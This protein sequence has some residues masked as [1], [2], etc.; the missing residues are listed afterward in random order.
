MTSGN[1]DTTD[2]DTGTSTDEDETC[3]LCD[4][5]NPERKGVL[6]VNN[7]AYPNT[8]LCPD[9]YTPLEELDLP[10][11]YDRETLREMQAEAAT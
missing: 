2:S 1:A 6:V 3:E 11:G 9:H 7:R 5:P 4:N 10:H 8:P